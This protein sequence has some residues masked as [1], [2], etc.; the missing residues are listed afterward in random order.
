[1]TN[2][3]YKS[4]FV[5]IARDSILK[6]AGSFNATSYWT[7]RNKIGNVMRDAL[8][9]ELAKAYA[10]CESLQILK[11]DLPKSYEDSIVSTQVEVQKTSMRRF[12]QQAEL[13]RQNISVIRSEATQQIRVIN[14]TANAEAYKVKQFARAN[15]INTTITAESETYHNVMNDIGLTDTD[16]MQYIYLNSVSD[17][18]NANVL[19]GLKN[20]IVNLQ[21]NRFEN[22]NMPMRTNLR[23]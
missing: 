18:K 12:E 7:E 16:L 11:I 13:I 23:K 14:S 20:T 8:S 19:V 4:T 15:A 21:N 17:N 1:M 3:N 5:R 10:T 6:V 9:S 22:S 2:T